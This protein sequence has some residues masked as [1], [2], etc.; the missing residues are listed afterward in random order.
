M[1]KFEKAM[2]NSGND[3]HKSLKEC[4]VIT[5]LTSRGVKMFQVFT[6]KTKKQADEVFAWLQS[7]N[8]DNADTITQNGSV[9]ERSKN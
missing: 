5:K 4:G 1:T 6:C 2:W 9:I 7:H 3:F 8:K